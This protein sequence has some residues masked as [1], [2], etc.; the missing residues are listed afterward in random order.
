MVDKDAVSEWDE[1]WDKYFGFLTDTATN[2]LAVRKLLGE[3]FIPPEKGEKRAFVFLSAV[4]TAMVMVLNDPTISQDKNRIDY[5]K[6][7]DAIIQVGDEFGKSEL[8][9]ITSLTGQK[10]FY[11]PRGSTGGAPEG[12]SGDGSQG[13]PNI[14][15]FFGRGKEFKQG[16]LGKKQRIEELSD[17][18]VSAVGSLSSID[19]VF[20]SEFS[21]ENSSLAPYITLS[22]LEPEERMQV[23]ELAGDKILKAGYNNMSLVAALK[24]YIAAEKKDKITDVLVQY[25]MSGGGDCSGYRW[26]D[27]A[28]TLIGLG[29]E[30]AVSNAMHELSKGEYL[31]IPEAP[32]DVDISEAIIDIAKSLGALEK[33]E[34]LRD[35]LRTKKPSMLPNADEAIKESRIVSTA[36]DV[37]WSDGEDSLFRTAKTLFQQKDYA[38]AAVYQD[39]L[40]DHSPK[41]P[42]AYYDRGH[43]SLKLGDL[44]NA[45]SCF[46]RAIDVNPENAYVHAD[47]GYVLAKEGSKDMA[48][49]ELM[50]ALEKKPGNEYAGSLLETLPDAPEMEELGDVEYD[51]ALKVAG[52]AKIEGL[53]NAVMAYLA[54]GAEQKV[55]GILR[56]QAAC[57]TGSDVEYVVTHVYSPQ[58]LADLKTLGAELANAPEYESRMLSIPILKRTDT[59]ALTKLGDVYLDID[60]PVWQASRQAYGAI[61]H[62]PGLERLNQQFEDSFVFIEGKDNGSAGKS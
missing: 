19:G 22:R 45:L 21:Y 46:E 43:S 54:A 37:F 25:V 24:A 16:E 4:P 20:I 52:N 55:I 8:E 3:K 47:F 15:A 50:A 14:T 10:V 27:A 56:E 61:N 23:F 31:E 28:R 6:V 34:K 58:A 36:I 39:V 2:R 49:I 29:F 60:Q 51:K 48:R 62:Q 40:I 13:G 12:A 7:R 11:K 26:R 18:V 41:H 35:A 53:K 38:L 59:E 57:L 5:S 1:A 44:G 9:R 30:A 42:W 32:I 33:L 17:R